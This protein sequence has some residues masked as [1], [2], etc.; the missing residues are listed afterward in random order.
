[1]EEG[2]WPSILAKKDNQNRASHFKYRGSFVINWRRRLVRVR[3]V[4]E[5]VASLNEKDTVLETKIKKTT[6]TMFLI[7]S[8][9]FRE[10]PYLFFIRCLFFLNKARII[11][12]GAL[13]RNDCLF[14]FGSQ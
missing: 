6:S 12:T 7:F 2:I 9:M 4:N 3:P 11:Y 8:L 5:A 1:M 14:Y 13:F 10:R